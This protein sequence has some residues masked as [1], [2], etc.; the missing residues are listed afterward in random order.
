MAT[1]TSQER[2][3]QEQINQVLNYVK[4]AKTLLNKITS[5][6]DFRTS[7]YNQTPR[8]QQEFHKLGINLGDAIIHASNL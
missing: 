4:S 1:P 5:D 7:K 3:I 6:P 8:L 2:K